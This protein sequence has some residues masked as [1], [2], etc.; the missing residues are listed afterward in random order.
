MGTFGKFWLNMEKMRTGDSDDGLDLFDCVKL[1]EK[2]ITLLEQDN[3][4]LTCA[5]RLTILGLLPVTRGKQKSCSTITCHPCPVTTRT[6]LVKGSTRSFLRPPKFRSPPEVHATNQV[7]LSLCC[8]QLTKVTLIEEIDIVD[9]AR[10]TFIR[11]SEG[12]LITW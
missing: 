10:G 11:T 1:V 9:D 5:R 12:Y 7:I 3:V 4:N 2:T 6:C 8:L